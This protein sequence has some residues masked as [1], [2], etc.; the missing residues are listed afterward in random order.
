M[1]ATLGAPH[2]IGILRR[3]AGGILM[4]AAEYQWQLQHRP[5]TDSG[6]LSQDGLDEMVRE[7]LSEAES[8][9]MAIDA[10]RRGM[11]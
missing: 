10:L 11:E 6:P 7:R 1:S 4:A 8:L 3:M 2:A 5:T 9:L